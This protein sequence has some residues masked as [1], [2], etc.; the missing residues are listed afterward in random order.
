MG[1][2][3]LYEEIKQK[4]IEK[5]CLIG[6]FK[7]INY[8]LQFNVTYR[9]NK[10]LIR[11]YEGKK[12][13][14]IDYSQV[15][16]AVLLDDIHK[17]LD[18][19]STPTNHTNTI[20]TVIPNY[21]IIGIDESG[22]GDFFGPLIIAGV[23]IGIDEYNK[24]KEIGVVD[25]KRLSDSQI[26]DKAL[27]IKAICKHIK[28]VSIHNEKYNDLYDEIKNLNKL[29]AWGH[30]RC[31]EN[32]L[33]SVQA[34]YALSDKFGDESLIK[35][36]L[37]ERGK[38][39]TLFQEHKAERHISVA[40]ASILARNEYLFKLSKLRKTYNIDFPKGACENSVAIGKQ[41][42]RA[43][44]KKELKKVSKLHFRTSKLIFCHNYERHSI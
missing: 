37:L 1:K 26:K 42:I 8:G 23:Y 19:D 17:I 30:A 28:I 35:N 20:H 33:S 6:N 43:Y 2:F 31:I 12:G 41:F 38:N 36:A 9:H 16:N 39:I 27:N 40:A 22:K 5:E 25:S 7:K 21:D 44:G 18:G 13:T 24:L 14:K 10:G 15:K 3:E 29:L 4:L 34:N 32:L 11:I